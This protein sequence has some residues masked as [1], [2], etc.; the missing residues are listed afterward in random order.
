MW[1]FNKCRVC[2]GGEVKRCYS[3]VKSTELEDTLIKRQ[4]MNS[5]VG[6]IPNPSH[7][8]RANRKEPEPRVNSTMILTRVIGRGPL[9]TCTAT[10]FVAFTGVLA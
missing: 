10:G 9:F 2:G 3:M 6:Y 1:S 5:Q 8:I 4:P 7:P